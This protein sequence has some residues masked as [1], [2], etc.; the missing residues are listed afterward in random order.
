MILQALGEARERFDVRSEDGFLP[1]WYVACEDLTSPAGVTPV[2]RANEL[3]AKLLADAHQRDVR[4]FFGSKYPLLT[5]FRSED[6]LL[7]YAIPDIS[8]TELPILFEV[9]QGAMEDMVYEKFLISCAPYPDAT[10]WSGQEREA[11]LCQRFREA[12][13]P[14]PEKAATPPPVDRRTY[15]ELIV[16]RKPW[17]RVKTALERI[18]RRFPLEI[19]SISPQ[20][21]TVQLMKRPLREKD[22]SWCADAVFKVDPSLAH[23]MTAD[24]LST[25][26]MTAGTIKM[27][28]EPGMDSF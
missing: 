22:A 28:F 18:H 24:D 12:D 8:V 5:N 15:A 2:E 20:H 4:L 11:Y 3:V 14:S 1:G 17:K 27:Q 10:G 13:A 6:C 19:L 9:N 23:S 25:T 16:S 7:V 21:V 26:I